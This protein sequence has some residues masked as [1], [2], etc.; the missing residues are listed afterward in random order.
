MLRNHDWPGN[1]RQLRAAIERACIVAA[2]ERIDVR[3]LPPEIVSRYDTDGREADLA[4]LTW[5][6]AMERGRDEV[7]RRY[8]EALLRRSQG[9]VAEASARAGVERESLYR[10]MRRYGVDPDAFRSDG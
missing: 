8:L 7:A 4:S 1:V 9:K 10:L 2:S 6:E 3:D 5:S